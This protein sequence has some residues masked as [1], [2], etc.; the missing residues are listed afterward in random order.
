MLEDGL[1]ALNLGLNEVRGFVT[2]K[3][4]YVVC[5]YISLMVGLQN[6]VVVT[7]Y[8]YCMSMLRPVP[9]A[10]RIIR[11]QLAYFSSRSLGSEQ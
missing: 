9:M 4:E 1:N 8:F 11:N 6:Q 2:L 10:Q 7:K 5:R 3:R